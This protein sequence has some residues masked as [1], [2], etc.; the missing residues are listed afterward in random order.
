MRQKKTL[1]KTQQR[2]WGAVERVRNSTHT[3]SNHTNTAKSAHLGNQGRLERFSYPINGIDTP[4]LALLEGCA[5]PLTSE[6]PH[7]QKSIKSH[8]YQTITGSVSKPTS[9]LVATSHQQQSIQAHPRHSRAKRQRLDP[10][11]E[12]D[13]HYRRY[14]TTAQSPL[15]CWSKV[16]TSVTSAFAW[17]C[18]AK[19]KANPD[20]ISAMTEQR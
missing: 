15:R 1:G 4:Q 12:E 14:P 2:H 13:L 16:P 20:S 3:Q 19:R 11:A 7:E 5:P 18:E 8:K 9:E 17:S 10:W 6:T